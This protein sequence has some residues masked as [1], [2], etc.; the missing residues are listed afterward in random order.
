MTQ[1][2]YSEYVPSQ[3]P[4]N[5]L[6]GRK[7]IPPRII[8]SFYLLFNSLNELAFQGEVNSQETT[9]PTTPEKKL[10]PESKTGIWISRVP[11]RTIVRV[12]VLSNLSQTTVATIKPI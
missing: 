2:F 6:G 12:Y 5:L 8:F 9:T 7:R 4:V 11:A 3:K 10:I 1:V